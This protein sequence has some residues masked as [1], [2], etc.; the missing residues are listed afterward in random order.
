MNPTSCRPLGGR[1]DEFGPDSPAGMAAFVRE[2]RSM[3]AIMPP[4]GRWTMGGT[5][6]EIGPRNWRPSQL[7]AGNDATGANNGFRVP[8]GSWPP[9][10]KRHEI[11]GPDYRN[12]SGQE[13]R[14][15]ILARPSGSFPLTNAV[16]D[17]PAPEHPKAR[18]TPAPATIES[19]E[20]A[21][22][23]VQS[24]HGGR[25]ARGDQTDRQ[26]D[27]LS[28][29]GFKSPGPHRIPGGAGE[30]WERSFPW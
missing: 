2:P 19:I 21:V 30:A 1:Q 15:G 14:R 5:R 20:R 18:Q 24:R 3:T 22:E 12:R 4:L 28:G 9:A 7:G 25:A 6:Q 16:E 8:N 17:S 26:G 27:D 13:A 29:A 10:A 23:A 11:S